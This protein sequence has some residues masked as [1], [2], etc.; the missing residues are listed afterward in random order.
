MTEGES[1]VEKEET[2][3]QA[4]SETE[5]PVFWASR[6]KRIYW[7][8]SRERLKTASSLDGDNIAYADASKEQIVMKCKGD[9][10]ILDVLNYENVMAAEHIWLLLM[11][12]PFERYKKRYVSLAAGRTQDR[13]CERERSRVTVIIMILRELNPEAA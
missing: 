4:E 1:S 7:F 3:P 12:V 9:F 2:A 10:A 6:P 11:G 5:V 8:S 13:V